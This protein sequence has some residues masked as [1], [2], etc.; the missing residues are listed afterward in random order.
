MLLPH[1]VCSIKK[2]DVME[3]AKFNKE[4]RKAKQQRDKSRGAVQRRAQTAVTEAR[5]IFVQLHL[6]NALNLS[7]GKKMEQVCMMMKK[8]R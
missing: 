7:M 6:T 5:S 3:S 2:S 4:R 1:E 8:E